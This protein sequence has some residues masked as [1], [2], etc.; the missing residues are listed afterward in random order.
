[1]RLTKP[2]PVNTASPAVVSRVFAPGSD[3]D[4][5]AM[6]TEFLNQSP[7]HV[8]V[9]GHYHH[10]YR[11]LGEPVENAEVRSRRIHFSPLA[12]P[13]FP[14][15]AA[16]SISPGF[17]PLAFSQSWHPWSLADI[18]PPICFGCFSTFP[19][20][21]DSRSAGVAASLRVFRGLGLA[22]FF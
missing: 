9:V 8:V 19:P 11:L 22:P 1:M 14:L 2:K 16:A 17:P 21:V 18:E 7:V 5:V 12:L 10:L 20:L 15:S 4:R 3:D 6:A 13:P